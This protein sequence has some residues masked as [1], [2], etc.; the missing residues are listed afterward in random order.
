MKAPSSRYRVAV[1]PYSDSW[2]DWESVVEYRWS[3]PRTVMRSNPTVCGTLV[4]WIARTI[5]TALGDEAGLGAC[6]AVAGSL[7]C[8]AR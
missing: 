1:C 3:A 6:A 8:G 2:S 5:Q 7:R 4:M